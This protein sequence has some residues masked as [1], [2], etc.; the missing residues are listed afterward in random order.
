MTSR[1]RFARAPRV[2]VLDRDGQ[3]RIR[4][5]DEAPRS[6]DLGQFQG[7]GVEGSPQLLRGKDQGVARPRRIQAGL[8]MAHDARSSAVSRL[9]TASV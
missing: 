8:C 2:F 6:D 4:A 1:L 7:K 9:T 5:E 3:E